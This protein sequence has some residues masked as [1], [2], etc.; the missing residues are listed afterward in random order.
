VG[1]IAEELGI[2]P[3]F[4]EGGVALFDLPQVLLLLP[5]A[6]GPT[7]EAGLAEDAGGGSDGALKL[8]LPHQAGGPE[9][10]ALAGLEHLGLELGSCLV[11]AVLGGTGVLLEAAAALLEE[12]SVPEPDG[13][14]AAVE[15][16]ASGVDALAV[17]VEHQLQAALVLVV[18]GADHGRI[19]DGTHGGLLLS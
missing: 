5:L 13:V 17:G 19:P 16:P 9:G 6:A 10:D 2:Q 11:R 12:T 3:P 18:V 1:D 14:S 4:A 7:G 15:G 8:E